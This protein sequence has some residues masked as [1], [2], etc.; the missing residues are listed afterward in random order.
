MAKKKQKTEIATDK[1]VQG[2]AKSGR[3]WKE[4]KETFRKIQRTIP[5]KTKEQHLK[6]REEMKNIKALSRS[7]K[8]DKKQVSLIQS[9]DQ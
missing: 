3:F 5:K 2:I 6:F 4:K 8:D 9:H 7:I 1:K